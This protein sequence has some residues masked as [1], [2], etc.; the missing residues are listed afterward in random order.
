MHR[1]FQRLAA[2]ID[3]KGPSCRQMTSTSGNDLL[4]LRITGT[5]SYLQ[6]SHAASAAPQ[7]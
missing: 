5:S 4:V 6:R 2:T 1:Y 3:D 7:E